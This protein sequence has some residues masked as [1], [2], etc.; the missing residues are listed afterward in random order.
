MIT[1][2]YLAIAV[3]IMSRY[4]DDYELSYEFIYLSLFNQRVWN[5]HCRA[6]ILAGFR[7]SF[8]VMR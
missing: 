4:Y 8:P 6:V 1:V 3:D 5:W 2:T 7:I